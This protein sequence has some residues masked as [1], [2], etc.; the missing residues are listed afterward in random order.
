MSD[1]FG[2]WKR[3]DDDAKEWFLSLVGGSYLD[4]DQALASINSEHLAEGAPPVTEATVRTWARDDPEFAEA[5][6]AA[7]QFRE[8]DRERPARQSIAPERWPS[9]GRLDL[10]ADPYRVNPGEP[11]GGPHMSLADRLR[12]YGSAATEAER[13][14]VK[15]APVGQR[16]I[17][18]EDMSPQALAL[19]NAQQGVRAGAHTSLFG[20]APN[21]DSLPTP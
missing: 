11:S 3:S 8:E 1:R 7:R 6:K 9:R 21:P 14:E 5:L 12:N 4:D 15:H 19:A 13:P 16:F 10:K 18:I 20:G 2:R 17:P